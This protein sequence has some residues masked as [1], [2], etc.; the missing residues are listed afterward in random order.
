MKTNIRFLVMIAVSLLTVLGMSAQEPFFLH[1]E[2]VKLTYAD[3]DK[4]GKINS[5]TETTATKVTGDA[6]NC[7][8][9][10][11]MMV[12]DNKKNPV[13][14]QPMTQTFEVKNGT[15]TYDPKSLVGQIMEGMQ[16]T[17]TGTPFQLPS[18]VKVGD[19]FGDYTIT[20][21]L[22]GIKTNT[23]VTGVKAVAETTAT[24]VTGDADNCTVTY[25]MM[26]MDNKK[27]PVLKQP[28][29]QTFEVKNGTVT[30]DPKSLVGQI[31][32]G[33][34]VTVTGT[35]FQ[36]PSNVKVGDTFGDYTITLNLAGIKTNTEV[37]GV[38]AVAEETLDVNG[39]SIDCV[40]IENTTVSKV[41]GIKQTA[42]QKIWYG[43]GIGPVKTNMYNKKGK[44]MTSQELVSI[45]GL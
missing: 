15:V 39:T 18:N 40:V 27:N 28:M 32:E 45:E 25:S 1:K 19:T 22:A 44:L 41:I 35:P 30:Y 21:N 6:D 37:T 4:K 36:L 3:K 9:T 38:K 8:V 16:V 7:T 10:Y 24:K 5:Y 31:M 12:M 42:I 17:V 43:H 33:M 29:T 23:E 26:V 20:L 14:K 34:Q 11:S 2:G 13:L